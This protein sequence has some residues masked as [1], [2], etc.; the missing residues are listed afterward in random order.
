MFLL[1]C[2]CVWV[3]FW[4]GVVFCCL[5]FVFEFFL[6]WDRVLACTPAGLVPFPFSSFLPDFPVLGLQAW[7]STPGLRKRRQKIIRDI[8]KSF[9]FSFLHIG[10]LCT[11]QM[12]I[13][14][15]LF[16]HSFKNK[17]D[18]FMYSAL[19][20]KHKFFDTCCRVKKNLRVGHTCFR[21]A[22]P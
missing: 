21:A 18:Y 13:F 14:K 19:I 16:I 9:W 17:I 3:L 5:F 10:T 7:D 6:F 1:T 22:F 11:I 12:L 8:S 20:L 4:G 15:E 2:F